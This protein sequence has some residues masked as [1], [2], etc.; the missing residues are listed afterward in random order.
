TARFAQVPGEQDF[1]AAP[2]FPSP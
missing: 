2:P 1:I